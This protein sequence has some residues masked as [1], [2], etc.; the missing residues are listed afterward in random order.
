MF[1][2][3]DESRIRPDRGGGRDTLGR[4]IFKPRGWSM[5]DSRGSALDPYGLRSYLPFRV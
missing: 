1:G 2:D 5:D 3:P 4:E